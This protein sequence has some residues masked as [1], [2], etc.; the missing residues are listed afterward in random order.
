MRQTQVTHPTQ[1]KTRW[2]CPGT[3]NEGAKPREDQDNALDEGQPHRKEGKGQRQMVM[4][5][6]MFRKKNL[7]DSVEEECLVYSTFKRDSAGRS[8]TYIYTYVD[9]FLDVLL[10]LDTLPFAPR[11]RADVS[12]AVVECWPRVYCNPHRTLDSLVSPDASR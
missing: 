9:H 3:G 10:S 6:E 5:G 1:G 11:P 7:D 12:S 2:S 8:Y 4:V